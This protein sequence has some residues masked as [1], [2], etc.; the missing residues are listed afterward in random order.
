MENAKSIIK[1]SNTFLEAKNDIMFQERRDEKRNNTMANQLNVV[2]MENWKKSKEENLV[3]SSYR[4]GIA[5][6]YKDL[7]WRAIELRLDVKSANMIMETFNPQSISH[8]AESVYYQDDIS[9][10]QDELESINEETRDILSDSLE[11]HHGDFETYQIVYQ[12]KRALVSITNRVIQIE[13]KI[14]Y[15]DLGLEEVNKTLN[16]TEIQTLAAKIQNQIKV[17]G[18]LKEA[19]KHFY[20]LPVQWEVTI[21]PYLVK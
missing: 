11:G 8:S 15:V 6:R 12:R 2:C 14:P 13:I 9:E 20:E 19:K 10:Y 4:D 3:L 18:I 5:Q 16:K 1:H 21:A 7:F 17:D